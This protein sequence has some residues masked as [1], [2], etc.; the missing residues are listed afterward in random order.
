MLLLAYLLL[1]QERFSL[2]EAAV[3]AEDKVDW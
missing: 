1:L 3:A 2:L